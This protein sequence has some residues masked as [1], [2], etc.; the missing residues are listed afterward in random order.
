MQCVNIKRL[1]YVQGSGSMEIIRVQSMEE[2]NQCFFIRQKVFVE[3]QG[4][5]ADIEIDEY[6]V[7]PDACGHTLLLLNGEPAATGRWRSY[8][9]DTVKLQ[10]LA[11]L[12]PYRGLGMGKKLIDAMEQQA[13]EAGFTYCILDGQ[14][15]AESFYHKL[16]YVT[17]SEQPFE[18]A[19]IMHVRMQKKL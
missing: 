3:E 2:L 15:H 14:C 4:V 1:Q 6:D 10:R 19:G 18:E 17:I 9:S 8:T 16:G 13:H 5:P 7:S 12:I 11:V